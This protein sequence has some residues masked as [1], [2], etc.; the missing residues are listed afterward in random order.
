MQESE[1]KHVTL[2]IEAL[3]E[4]S[5]MDLL[6]YIYSNNLPATL[7]SLLDL[8]LTADKFEVVSCLRDCTRALQ[9]LPMTPESASIYLD[10]PQS[11]LMS[12][13]VQPLLDASKQFLVTNFWNLDTF[14]E[15]VLDLPLLGLQAVLSSDNLEVTSEIVV[16]DTVLAWVRKHYPNMEERR[17]ILKTHLLHLVRFP[18]LTITQLT[19]D[20][21]TCNDIDP[22]HAS[23]IVICALSYKAET[24][25]SRKRCLAAEKGIIA[26]YQFMERVQTKRP[27]DLLQWNPEYYEEY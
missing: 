7:D 23:K 13:T 22:E 5:F 16:Y 6:K 17:E 14:Q 26:S 27:N 15:E 1:L 21:L 11:L 12:P 20:V 18:F 9:N 2:R 4:V 10:L 8:S 19:K 24:D 25:S 3:E